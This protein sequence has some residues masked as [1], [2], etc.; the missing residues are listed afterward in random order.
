M[1]TTHSPFFVNGLRAN[2]VWAL[3]RD[4]T[5]FT[6]ACRAD[7]MKGVREFMDEGA[8]LGELWMEGH[9]SVGD[10]QTASGGQK[11]RPSGEGESRGKE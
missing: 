5:G 1:V 2:E 9:F 8:K 11:P 4:Q 6:R 3:Y 10:P 7:R